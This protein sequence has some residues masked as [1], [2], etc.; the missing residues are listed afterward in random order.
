MV[1]TYYNI[2][3]LLPAL[4]SNQLILTAN[5]RLRNHLLRAYI[6][7]QERQGNHCLTNPRVFTLQQWID[8]QWQSLQGLGWPQAYVPIATSFQRQWL[9]QNIIQSSSL[10]TGLL[11]PTPLAQAADTALHNMELWQL[12]EQDVKDAEPF[13]GAQSNSASF[14]VWL[15]EF[16]TRLLQLGLI[17]QEQ[18]LQ[19]LITAY[20][21]NLLVQESSLKLLGFDDIPPLQLQLIHNASNQVEHASQPNRQTCLYRTQ[22]LHVDDEILAAALWSHEQLKANPTAMIGIIVPNL[23]QT[24]DAIERAFTHVFEPLAALPENLR[25]TLPFNFS[26]GTPL[27][28]CPLMASTLDLLALHEKQWPLE[29]ICQSLQSPFWAN[30]KDEMEFR[31]YLATILRQQ[32]RFF[33]SA[34]D[35]RHYAQTL[36]TQIPSPSNEQFTQRL[37]HIESQRHTTFGKH[38]AN[39]WSD[40][41]STLLHSLGWPGQRRLDSQE[42]QQLSLWNQVMETFNQLDSCNILLTYTE[43]RQVLRNIAGKTPFQAQT[44]MSPIQILGALEGAGLEFSH[45]WVM[46]L[47]HR[48][49]PPTPAPNPLLPIHLQR[50]HKMPHASAERELHFARSLTQHYRQCAPIIVFSSALSGDDQELSPS[51]LIRDIPLTPVENL[52]R[53]LLSDARRF[54]QHILES[55]QLEKITDVHGPRVD[56]T[57]EIIRGG[58]AIFKEQANCPFNAFAKLRL[59]ARQ[60]LPP[61]PGF[62]AIERGNMLHDALA[63]IWRLLGDQSTLLAMSQEHIDSL[64]SQQIKESVGWVKKRRGN[65]ISAYYADLEEERLNRLITAWIEQEKTRPSFRVIAIEEPLVIEFSGLPLNLRIDR[66]DQLDNGDLLLIDYK[67]GQCNAQQWFSDRPDEPQLPLYALT[68]PHPPAAIAFAQINARHSQ[69][70]GAGSLQITHP[71]I[72]MVPDWSQQLQDWQGVLAKLAEDFMAGDARLDFSSSKAKS[73]AEE[74]LPLNRLAEKNMIEQ[75]QE[76]TP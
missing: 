6:Q 76:S 15:G 51:A 67:T 43:A 11:Q 31:I 64:I 8:K 42:H 30:A 73:Y 25:F 63:K 13:L 59:D 33:I 24:R 60:P 2:D 26:A 71:G 3:S 29:E 16:R 75:Y 1:D 46:G 21:Q 49:W 53:C 40:V 18:A 28:S 61:V 39:Y 27:A 52:V 50:K 62:S 35:L 57:R 12:D 36:S 9:W 10:T 70:I 44:P 22:C 66:I 68:S 37:L 48:Q 5:N 45:C 41:F 69:W 32:G 17:T 23:G 47:H 65:S 34:G 74:L 72:D 20:Q 58:A 14:L 54:E 38:P 4:N 56:V 7:Y 55:Q 19:H